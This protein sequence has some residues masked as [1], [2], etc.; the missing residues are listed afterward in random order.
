MINE[1]IFENNFILKYFTEELQYSKLEQSLFNSRLMLIPSVVK[2]FIYT[3][4]SK[5]CDY[6]IK[7]D[8][9]RNENL[10]WDDFLKELSEHISNRH[11]VAIFANPNNNILFKF[12]EYTFSLFIPFEKH[13]INKNIYN[14]VGQPTFILEEQFDNFSITPDIGLFI[15]GI[16]FSF[17]QLKLTHKGQNADKARGQIIGDYL[18]TIKRVV[19]PQIDTILLSDKEKNNII[20]QKMKYFHSMIHLVAM[21]ESIAYV[22]RGMGKHYDIAYDFIKSNK[23]NDEE[24]KNEIKRNFL[25]DVVYVK[26]DH[27]SHLE[28]A[29]KFL[30]NLYNKDAIQNEILIYN[31][32]YYETK[33]D[34]TQG[35]KKVVIKN[36]TTILSY[37]RPNQKYGVDKVINEVIIKYENEDNPNYEI[38]KLEQKLISQNIPEEARKR[39]LEKR[40][41]YRNNQNIYSLLLQYAAGFGKTYILCW[42]SMR[43]KDLLDNNEKY[44][45]DKILIISDRVD[46]RDQVDLAMRNMNL[47]KG[48]SK[49]AETKEELTKLLKNKTAR[50]IIVNI[51]KFPFLKDILTEEDMKLLS[52][53]RIAFL[54]DEIHRSNSGKQH[55][56]MTDLFDDIADNFSVTS[57]KKKNL[58]IGLTATPTDHNLSRWGEYQGCLEDIKWIPFDTY[59]MKQAIADGFILDPTKN[60]V[61]YSI[62]LQYEIPTSGDKKRNA[63]TKEIYENDERIQIVSENVAKT[64]LDV[65]YKKIRKSGKGMLCCYSI[66]AAK[67]YFDAI[68]QELKRLSTL[69]QYEKSNIGN[70]YMVYTTTQEDI[71]AHKICGFASEKEAISAFK[72]DKNGLMIVVDKLQTGFDEPKLHTLFLDKEINGI[73]CVQTV[74]RVNRTTKNKT[75]CLVV[76]YSINNANIK[77]INESFHKYSGVV[78]SEF[79][80][81]TVKDQLIKLY[82]DITDTGYYKF[83]YN[84]FIINDNIEFAVQRKSE[85]ENMVVTDHGKELAIRNANLY[86]DYISKLGLINGLVSL[87]NKYSEPLFIKFLK[88][89]LE[90]LKSLLQIDKEKLEPLDFWIEKS[91]N[92]ETDNTIEDIS[93]QKNIKA[94]KYA[95][96]ISTGYVSIDFIIAKNNEE[97]KKESLMI[98]YQ[99]K[100]QLLYKKL[101]ELDK[102]EGQRI[103]LKLK[104]IEYYAD[105]N[106][107]EEFDTLFQQAI[108]RLKNIEN[109][110][111]FVESIKDISPLIMEDFLN[112][113]RKP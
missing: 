42:L 84:D 39:A 112:Y 40:K 10:F 6:I 24:I 81:L 4:H 49:E 53:K 89:Y 21:D 58:I 8:Y 50:I 29:K 26:E 45:F 61:A 51:Q 46:L 68:N 3:N 113:L 85:L 92:I 56:E 95:T 12:K 55:N 70:V 88:E 22:L 69:P 18:E 54:I 9:Q 59:T 38:E 78:V 31:F 64:L 2:N 5:E 17:I 103:T 35:H 102:K 1:S 44:L 37:P 41:A 23:A 60:K 72:N 97:K 33:S 7:N 34:Y 79:N 62:E 109:M 83:Y 63:T 111:L 100:L 36:G 73:T 107:R 57:K 66:S 105:D 14:V 104:K 76:D 27:L 19:H 86:L 108:R 106:L 65:T 91:N 32:L 71:P 47:D 87:D 77:N 28:R 48:L 67:K 93:H 30:Y 74:C 96:D 15:N 90:L 98:D 99:E 20:S 94:K 101:E 82:K 16:L 110:A 52:E 13:K 80:S 11:N 43:L 75:D 25:T